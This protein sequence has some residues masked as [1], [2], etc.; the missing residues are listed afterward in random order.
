MQELQREDLMNFGGVIPASLEMAT[1]NG[2]QNT[3][4]QV[5]PGKGPPLKVVVCSP[6]PDDESLVGALPLRLLRECGA[7]VTNCAITLGSNAAQRER[8][9]RELKAA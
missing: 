3:R 5:R 4:F 7:K 6:H 8:R 9:L 2:F 1:H